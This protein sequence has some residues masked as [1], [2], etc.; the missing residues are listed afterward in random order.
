MFMCCVNRSSII[1][2]DLFWTTSPS[3]YHSH[4]QTL[5]TIFYPKSLFT[6][7]LFLTNSAT[8]AMQ[9]LLALSSQI[10]GQLEWQEA[11]H[12]AKFYI[13][14]HKIKSLSKNVHYYISQLAHG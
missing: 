1:N 13:C 3:L 11:M 7:P 2:L 8:S 10:D 4:P 14:G 5:N 6:F 9:L 12:T